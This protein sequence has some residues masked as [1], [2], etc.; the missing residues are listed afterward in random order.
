MVTDEDL[1]TLD[2]MI[3][4]LEHLRPALQVMKDRRRWECRIKDINNIEYC[5]ERVNADLRKIRR[6]AML[7]IKD[8]D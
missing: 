2:V 1:K 5:G 6:L 8:V 3:Y 7:L 4:I